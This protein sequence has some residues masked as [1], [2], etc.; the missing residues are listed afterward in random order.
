MLRTRIRIRD[1]TF[2]LA[3]GHDPEQLETAIV[4]AVRANGGFVQFVE[5]GNKSV[6]V[7][8]SPGVTVILEH[9]EVDRDSRDD[10]DLEAPYT[11]PL[12]ARSYTAYDFSDLD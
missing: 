5:V 8:I 12:G 2:Y 3:Q 10:G 4:D 6:S 1:T 7:L 11:A 9:E